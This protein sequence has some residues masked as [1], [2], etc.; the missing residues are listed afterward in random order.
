MKNGQYEYYHYT[1]IVLG[2][3]TLKVKL[4]IWLNGICHKRSILKKP[5]FI[6]NTLTL[7]TVGK[8]QFPTMTKSLN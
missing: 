8:P 6:D 3:V 7:L 2:V 5:C 4:N 1:G